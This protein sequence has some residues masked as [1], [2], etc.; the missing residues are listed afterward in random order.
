M[1]NFGDERANIGRISGVGEGDVSAVIWERIVEATELDT[2]LSEIR[3][4]VET[5]D[6]SDVQQVGERILE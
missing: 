3:Q 2:D 4:A 1:R 5:G 6:H